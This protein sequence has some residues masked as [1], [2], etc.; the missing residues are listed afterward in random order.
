MKQKRKRRRKIK[1]KCV[2]AC[3]VIACEGATSL[4]VP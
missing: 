3:R 1:L 2:H 4:F